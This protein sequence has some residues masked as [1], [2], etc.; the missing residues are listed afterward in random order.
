MVPITVSLLRF[1]DSK[2]SSP[3][4][5]GQL[6]PVI[7]V[8]SSRSES[9]QYHGVSWASCTLS[10][11]ANGIADTIVQC[12]RPGS[13]RKLVVTALANPA[14]QVV[15]EGTRPAWEFD[16]KRLTKLTFDD[17][18]A[19]LSVAAVMFIAPQREVS[20]RQAVDFAAAWAAHPGMAFGYVDS[21]DDIALSRCLEIRVLPTTLVLIDG[22]EIARLEGWHTQSRISHVLEVAAKLGEPLFAE[23]RQP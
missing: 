18:A 2:H 16:V 21:F 20:M 5:H 8:R 1:V 19:S 17:F 23:V 7:E 9:Y 14:S 13:S 3:R 22:E 12:R 10:R 4:R 15:R 11:S 6:S